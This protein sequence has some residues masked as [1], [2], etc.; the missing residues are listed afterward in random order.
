[1]FG[2]LKPKMKKKQK[3]RCEQSATLSEK[4]K[5]KKTGQNGLYWD[6]TVEKINQQ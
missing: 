1:M 5:P 2:F 3:K 6:F 4:K